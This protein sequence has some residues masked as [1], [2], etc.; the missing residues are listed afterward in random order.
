MGGSFLAGVISA[1]RDGVS[2][3]MDECRHDVEGGGMEVE[4]EWG[5]LRVHRGHMA[6]TEGAV[7]E[8]STYPS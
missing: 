5:C 2:R 7:C 6:R 1:A 4:S 8:P 3:R